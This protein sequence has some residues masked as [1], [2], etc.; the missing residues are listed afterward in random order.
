MAAIRPIAVANSA[1]RYQ[2]PPPPA[3]C[4]SR[5]RSTGKL[6][7]DAPDGAEQA[8]E[9]GP[10]NRRSPAPGAAVSSRSTSRAIRDVHHF[11]DPHLKAGE[12]ARLALERA[13]PLAH[14]SYETRRHRFASV[15]PRARGKAPR[16][17]ARTRTPVRSGPWRAW[18]ANTGRS[19][20]SRS[21]RPRP[22]R[23]AGR[24]LPL[25]RPSGPE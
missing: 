8:D 3:R 10:R 1:S 14:G 25:S 13:L 17:I 4:F 11:L 12:G 16:S 24:A 23:R 21:P 2:G 6:G 15:L 9:R 5:Q 18:C 19:C 7:H 20:R 22:S